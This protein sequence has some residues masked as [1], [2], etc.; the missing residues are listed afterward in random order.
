MTAAVHRWCPPALRRLPSRLLFPRVVLAAG[1]LADP[2]LQ[3]LRRV[4]ISSETTK[5]WRPQVGAVCCDD[6][7]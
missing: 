2:K 3:R 7:L 5:F 1:I 6:V 4:K